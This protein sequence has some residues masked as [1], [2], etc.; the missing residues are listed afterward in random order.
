MYLLSCPDLQTLRTLSGHVEWVN[1]VMFLTDDVLLSGSE[2]THIRV[3]DLASGHC[4]NVITTFTEYVNALALS[5]SGSIFAA[6][7]HDWTV[8]VFDS[9]TF[10]E[11]A[12]VTLG[13]PVHTVCWESDGVVV[14]GQFRG[15]IV[16]I[17]V[18]SACVCRSFGVTPSP[19][20]L[21]VASNTGECTY[22]SMNSD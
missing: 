15:D 6:A 22:L 13:G 3:W 10:I 11:L 14:A 9:R 1:T 21:A 5:P 2:D 20:G 8:R 18:E 4:M 7:S 12:S 16:A 19:S 17:D